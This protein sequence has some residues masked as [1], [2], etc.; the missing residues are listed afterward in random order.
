M[1][2]PMKINSLL[3]FVAAAATVA[4]ASAFEWTP[5][6][7]YPNPSVDI[8]DTYFLGNLSFNCQIEGVSITDVMPVWVDEDNNEIK[9]VSGEQDPWGFDPTAFV[10]TFNESDFKAN[11]EYILTFPEGMLVNAAGEKSDKIQVPYTVDVPAL[12]AG[13]FEDFEILSITPDLSQDQAIWT[14]Q[15]VTVNTNHNDAIGLT[16]LTVTDTTTGEGIL[17]S[18]SFSVGRELGDSA[19]VSWEVVGTY[20]FFEGHSYVAEFTF[21]NGKDEVSEDGV[22]N[23]IVDRVSYEFTGRVEGFK[24]SDIELLGVEPDPFSTVINEPQQAV[25]TFTFSG[26]VTVYQA[27]TPL[28]QNGKN[29]YP[30]SCLSSNEDKTVWTLDLSDDSYVKTVDAALT[31]AI[32]AR[33]L[34]GFQVEGDFGEESE[35]CFIFDWKCDIGGKPIVVVSPAAGES[36]DCLSEVV[37]KSADGEPMTWTW[38]G[39]ANV[40][41]ELG[42]SVGMLVY[43]MPEEGE[44]PA[45]VEFRFTKWMDNSWNTFPIELVKGGTYSVVFD[46][47]CFVFGDQFTAVNSRSVK[48]SFS[49]TGALDD[50]PVVDPQEALKYTSVT[51][52]VGSTVDFIDEILLVFDEPVACEDFEVNVYSMDQTLVA[53]GVGRGDFSEPTMVIVTLNE[54]VTEAGRYDVVVPARVI[55]NGD[56]YESNGESGFCNPEYHLYYVIEGSVDPGVDPAQQEVFFF[57]RVSPESGSTVK[58]LEK[59]ELWYPDAVDTTGKDA[60]IYN[61]ADGSVVSD[62]LVIYDWDDLYK[63]NVEL[64]D[65]VTEAGVYE[66]VILARTICDGDFFMSDGKKGICNPEIKFTYTVD[67]DFNAVDSVAAAAEAD[68][69][70]IHG[71]LVL[72]N[73]SADAVKTLPK[74]IYVVGSRKV[75]VK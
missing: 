22:P 55:I 43:E 5:V 51:P 30:S 4:Q 12:A 52:E 67:P 61:T 41:D 31:I 28:G 53:T 29:V 59:I 68:V 3:A 63:I 44:D 60:V 15:V 39:E 54:P 49:I 21:Y 42:N 58:S 74:G 45:A 35:S 73:A 18:S 40:V 2:T 9:A 69:Y 24:Y 6:S 1:I 64:F 38:N 65:P 56:Y 10:Y 47:G 13:M 62:A 20:K 70:D 16:I 23:K 66:V 34:D 25:F 14:D 72:R 32:Y 46:P 37:V 71:R 19:P 17:Y 36:L 7:L 11:G 33:D 48:S 50:T 27:E 8:T 75:V 26:P 57:D